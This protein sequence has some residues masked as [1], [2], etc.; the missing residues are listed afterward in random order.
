MNTGRFGST[1]EEEKARLMVNRNAKITN[2]ETK[3]SL[4]CLMSYLIEKEMPEL[5]SIPDADLPQLLLDFY[6]NMRT[7]KGNEL[8][9]TQTLKCMRSNLNHHFKEVRNIDIISDP[10]FIKS[11]EMFKAVK[12]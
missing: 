3:S 6:T 12:V 10:R 1:S 7:K 2:R 9:N 4:N 11:N 5:S 8:Y